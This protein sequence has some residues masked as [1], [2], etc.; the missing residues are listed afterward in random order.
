MARLDRTR[1]V[2]VTHQGR[3]HLGKLLGVTFTT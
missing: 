3:D 1:A 2:R